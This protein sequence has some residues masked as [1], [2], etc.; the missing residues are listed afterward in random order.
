MLPQGNG[1]RLENADALD[2][3]YTV[4]DTTGRLG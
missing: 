1:R 4:P 2:P 3:R